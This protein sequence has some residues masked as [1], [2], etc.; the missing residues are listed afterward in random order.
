MQSETRPI[1]PQLQQESMQQQGNCDKNLVA[2]KALQVAVV[3]A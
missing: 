2:V 1:I 3:F